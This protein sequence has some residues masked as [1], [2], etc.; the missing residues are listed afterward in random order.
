[1][2]LVNCQAPQ[3]TGYY[4]FTNLST[5][6]NLSGDASWVGYVSPGPEFYLYYS[7]YSTYVNFGIVCRIQYESGQYQNCSWCGIGKKKY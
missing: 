4:Q 5:S 2:K 1:M 6:L 3:L 7:A